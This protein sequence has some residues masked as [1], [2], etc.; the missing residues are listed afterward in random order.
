MSD[1][2]S[3][4]VITQTILEEFRILRD[5]AY[6]LQHPDDPL[7]IAKT[8]LFRNF[9]SYLKRPLQHLSPNRLAAQST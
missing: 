2:S 1:T 6:H 7:P 4:S 9:G 3:D 8:V 5:E